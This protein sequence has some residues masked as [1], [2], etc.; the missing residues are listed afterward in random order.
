MVSEDNG[1]LSSPLFSWVRNIS[2][3]IV[4]QKGFNVRVFSVSCP[5]AVCDYLIFAEV[6]VDHHMRVV[7]EHL[8]TFLKRKWM[9]PR[10]EGRSSWV[11]LDC[12]QVII[13]LLTPEARLFYSMESLWGDLVEEVFFS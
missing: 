1:G 5:G 6:F 2:E 7:S 8:V 11:L 13:H 4:A 10:V 9:R 3:E 12:D